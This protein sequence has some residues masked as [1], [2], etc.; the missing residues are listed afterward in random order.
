MKNL[1]LFATIFLLLSCEIPENL[2][3]NEFKAI[4]KNNSDKEIKTLIIGAEQYVSKLKTYALTDS[5]VIKNLKSGE[6]KIVTITEKKLNSNDG[7]FVIRVEFIDGKKL[8]SGCCYL[9]NGS[10]LKACA[11]FDIQ[12]DT[13]IIK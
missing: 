11:S 1:L 6:S 4:V 2:Y 8:K 5:V 7:N 3:I 9:T 12:K 10:I 13:I